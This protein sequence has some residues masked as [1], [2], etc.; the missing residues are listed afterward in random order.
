MEK[1]PKHPNS[2]GSTEHVSESLSPDTSTGAKLDEPMPDSPIAS[3]RI[4]G[5][6]T[7]SGPEHKTGDALDTTPPP[8][9]DD[10]PVD[11]RK[12]EKLETDRNHLRA[13]NRLLINAASILS[14]QNQGAGTLDSPSTPCPINGQFTPVAQTESTSKQQQSGDSPTPQYDESGEDGQGNA[15]MIDIQL[16]GSSS[17]P[18]ELMPN[19]PSEPMCH[20]AATPDENK[21]KSV[22]LEQWDE[23]AQ[24]TVPGTRRSAQISKSGFTSLKKGDVHSDS[25]L[26][27]PIDS[28]ITTVETESISE[29]KTDGSLNTTPPPYNDSEMAEY[30]SGPDGQGNILIDT[31]TIDS[32][33][34][35]LP[36][37]SGNEE[38]PKHLN[39]IHDLSAEETGISDLSSHSLAKDKQKH[40]RWRIQKRPRNNQTLE[41]VIGYHLMRNVE[42]IHTRSMICQYINCH[43]RAAESIMHLWNLNR[44]KTR[45]MRMVRRTQVTQKRSVHLRL[46]IRRNLQG[47]HQT[48]FYI[49]RYNRQIPTTPGLRTQRPRSHGPMAI[50][51]K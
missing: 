7:E 3:H 5:Q 33:L 45:A 22:H 29:H 46:V 37:S 47:L 35:S 25:A 43:P 15:L 10:Y 6:I 17:N 41:P 21:G 32:S 1:T 36:L 16:S 8:N 20:R 11:S 38:H 51:M 26:S 30:T 39:M 14:R 4:N 19:L 31:P 13:Q 9:V 27:H 12:S 24:M 44:N 34:E 49:C 50:V 40:I 23:D 18:G 42:R 28:Q 48:P 2:T